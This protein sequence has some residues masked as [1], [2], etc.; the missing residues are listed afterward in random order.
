MSLSIVLYFNLNIEFFGM[1]TGFEYCSL[2]IRDTN[3]YI[4]RNEICNEMII[5]RKYIVLNILLQEATRRC[6][7]E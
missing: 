7:R 4:F 2:V 1:E 5:S 6:I 3:K